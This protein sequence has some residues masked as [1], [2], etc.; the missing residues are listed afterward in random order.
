MVLM[1][2]NLISVPISAFTQ[3]L[4]EISLL[5]IG[6]GVLLAI[7]TWEAVLFVDRRKIDRQDKEISNNIGSLDKEEVDTLAKKKFRISWISKI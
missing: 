5:W 4:F 3:P 1:G 2:Q 6:T 7:G